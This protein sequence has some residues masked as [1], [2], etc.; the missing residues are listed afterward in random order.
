MSAYD[1]SC[2]AII[3]PTAP[4]AW[5]GIQAS[6]ER[7]PLTACPYEEGSRE[8]YTWRYWYEHAMLMRAPN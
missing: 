1:T 5:L 6:M 8:A 4:E 3:V 2:H 7:M